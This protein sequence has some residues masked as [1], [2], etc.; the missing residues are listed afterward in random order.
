MHTTSVVSKQLYNVCQSQVLH[1]SSFFFFTLDPLSHSEGEDQL[2]D[3]V[4]ASPHR[5][6]Q[7][8]PPARRL[9][10]MSFEPTPMATPGRQRRR[11]HPGSP[12]EQRLWK[13]YLAAATALLQAKREALDNQEA[14]ARAREARERARE[15]RERD[16]EARERDLF[17]LDLE[18]KRADLALKRA[19]LRH[20]VPSGME[21]N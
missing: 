11:A 15:A 9:L 7:G 10:D 14:R 19:E 4:Q 6:E 2:P 12:A 18:L 17:E 8:E 16:R 20:F 1:S 3:P 13:E 5:E 21:V